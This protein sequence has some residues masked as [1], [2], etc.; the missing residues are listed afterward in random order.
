MRPEVHMKSRMKAIFDIY[1]SRFFE[2]C[3]SSG[4]KI[5]KSV[6][7]APERAH[8]RKQKQFGG[9]HSCDMCMAKAKSINIPGKKASNTKRNQ[10]NIKVL[11]K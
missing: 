8:N 11:K 10:I 2:Q 9:Y 1:L 7:D 5:L 6:A 3:A 4:L